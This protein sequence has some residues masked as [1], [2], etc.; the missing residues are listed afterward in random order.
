MAS[1]FLIIKMSYL[2]ILERKQLPSVSPCGG[3]E[4]GCVAHSALC[5][6]HTRKAT[7]DKQA[8]FQ[9]EEDSTE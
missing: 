2:G 1:S 9:L 8:S 5:L 3:S 6:E 7:R 4:V